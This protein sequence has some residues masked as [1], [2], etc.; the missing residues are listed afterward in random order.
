MG[1]VVCKLLD[2]VVRFYCCKT[3]AGT[4]GGAGCGLKRHGIDSCPGL[5][6]W[7]LELDISWILRVLL[8][9]SRR[10]KGLPVCLSQTHG[11]QLDDCARPCACEQLGHQQVLASESVLGFNVL[12]L[13]S[14]NLRVAMVSRSLHENVSSPLDFNVRSGVIVSTEF[15]FVRAF[16]GALSLDVTMRKSCVYL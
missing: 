6:S 7:L 13:C 8:Q 2:S 16:R 10:F 1:N 4:F 11:H 5:H 12:M 14:T 9:S 15:C 3:I